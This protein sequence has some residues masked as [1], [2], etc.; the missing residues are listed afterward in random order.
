MVPKH[1]EA[2][3]RPYRSRIG[4]AGASNRLSLE[5][6]PGVA[7]LA[8]APHRRLLGLADLLVVVRLELLAVA[9]DAEVA[10]HVGRLAEAAQSLLDPA[11]SR[12][13]L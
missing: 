5:P 6:L 10:H 13:R 8:R 1:H 9:N 11:C 3:L 2:K 12:H 7:A 4:G